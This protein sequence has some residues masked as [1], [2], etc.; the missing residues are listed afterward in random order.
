MVD[1]QS[2]LPAYFQIARDL[3]RRIS[4]GEWKPNEQLPSEIELAVQ[5]SVSRMTLRQ[6][7]TEL[8]KDN[9]LLRRRG[10]GTFVN[11]AFAELLAGNSSKPETITPENDWMRLREQVW[12][13]LQPVA[14]PDSRRHYDFDLFI[15]DFMGSQ[16]CADSVRL[17]P[18]YQSA[19]F[20]FMA[21]D[22][23]LTLLR[24]YAVEDGKTLLLATAGLARGFRIILPGMV[25]AG[26]EPLAATLDGAEMLSR[27][28]SLDEMRLLG[29]LDLVF[30]GVSLVTNE[31]VRW[32]SGYGYF[33][34]EWAIFRDLG[35]ATANTPVI[36][37]AHDCQVV[38]LALKPSASDATV[39]ILVT[40]GGTRSIQHEQSKP[41]GIQWNLI[42]MD[43]LPRI[44]LLQELARQNTHPA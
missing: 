41:D 13:D 7:L 6:A 2:P 16:V 24:R 17:M 14:L 25:P 3:R 10:A 26:Q 36:G 29:V 27:P 1:R 15:P 9:L 35:I 5:Y 43:L 20:V 12:K 40:P 28:V 33:D 21:P 42:S 37:V 32:G 30:T 8:D 4:S 44:P 18:E 39:D 23:S 38:D 11:L 19:R 22:N 34:L 31:G